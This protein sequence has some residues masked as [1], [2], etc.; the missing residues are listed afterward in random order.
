MTD[1]DG[2]TIDV[3]P[4]GP[5]QPEEQHMTPSIGRI[6]HYK[7]GPNDPLVAY[8]G[9]ARK[10]DD[11]MAAVVTRVWTDEMVNLVVF[12][13]NGEPVPRT[14]VQRADVA[15]GGSASWDWPPRV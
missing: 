1:H 3:G 5:E 4:P 12:V 6:V 9:Q 15:S 8:G 2:H 11:V 13:D 10:A 14:S 7:P